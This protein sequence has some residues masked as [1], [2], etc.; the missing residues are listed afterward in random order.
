MQGPAEMP[1][2]WLSYVAVAALT[3]ANARRVELGGLGT[4][5][6]LQDPLGAVF[7][8]FEARG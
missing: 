7:A 5:A 3:R 8:M 2:H 1:A 6:V 4:F